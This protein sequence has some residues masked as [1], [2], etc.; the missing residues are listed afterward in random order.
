VGG[1]PRTGD[2]LERGDGLEAS[3]EGGTGDGDGDGDGDCLLIRDDCLV[4]GVVRA[5][6]LLL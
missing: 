1:L 4:M 5:G 2:D 6:E 3:R